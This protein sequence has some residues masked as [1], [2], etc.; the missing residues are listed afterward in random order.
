[1]KKRNGRYWAVE[2]GSDPVR[3]C[4][5]RVQDEKV[6][7]EEWQTQP[8]AE[9]DFGRFCREK[10]DRRRGETILC[11]VP[12]SEVLLKPFVGP[13]GDQ[14]DIRKI[15]ALKLEQALGELDE[16][17]T[18]W[19]YVED[20]TTDE[21]KRT[22]VMAA[23]ISRE[24]V[25]SLLER[26]FPNGERPTYVECGALA[27]LRAHLAL[28]PHPLACEIVADCA[29]DGTSL[30]VI[31]DGIIESA[32]FVPGNRPVEAVGNEI[33]RLI[34]YL[35]GRRESIQVESVVCLG[36]E[37]A[38]E[39]ADDLRR[40]LDIPVV[41]RLERAA[42]WVANADALPPDWAESW[43]RVVGLIRAA[44]SG[45]GEAINFLAMEA[46]R[47]GA[48]PL[49]P[50]LAKIQT[51]VLILLMIGLLLA[52]V[53]VQRAANHQREAIMDKVIQ[54]AR[55]ISA[56]LQH[57]EQSLAILRRFAADKFPMTRLLVEIAEI[58]P[59][60][61][62]LDTLSLNPDGSLSLTGRCKTYTDVQEFTRKVTA[63][64]FFV[65]ADA[66]SSRKDREGVTFKMTFALNP[67][68]KKAG[69]K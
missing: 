36:G 3:L 53:F 61:V 4:R 44:L 45:T 7:V 10:T 15:T 1:M 8:A 28:R 49:L 41:N 27:G 39:L 25:Q 23:A 30:F 42:E 34:L 18:L 9:F 40:T 63:S 43:H 62:T 51:P 5:F 58:A 35:R 47:R 21:G 50:A 68:Y 38:K 59:Q 13:R 66:P 24:Y 48:Q 55:L 11:T 57:S 26:H 6:T 19:G 14:V 56:D 65:R 37:A 52:T 22:H 20:G 31:M 67:K 2:L 46:P 69:A 54:R 32:H 60:G 17:K 33:R 16:N 29:A 64:D 12:R